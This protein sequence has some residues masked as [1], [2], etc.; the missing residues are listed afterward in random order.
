M[1]EFA[2]AYLDISLLDAFTGDAIELDPKPC[3]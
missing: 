3:R 1:T 2:R